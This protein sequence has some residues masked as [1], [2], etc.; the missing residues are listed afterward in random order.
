MTDIAAKKEKESKVRLGTNY[1][2]LWLL[3][4]VSNLGDGVAMVACP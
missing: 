3:S 2:R 4:V 1:W